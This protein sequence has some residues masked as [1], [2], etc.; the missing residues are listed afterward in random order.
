MR[1]LKKYQQIDLVKVATQVG[2]DVSIWICYG[3]GLFWLSE[4]Q[5]FGLLYLYSAFF[6]FIHIRTFLLQH[7]CGHGSLFKSKRWSNFWGR[8]FSV[9]STFPYYLWKAD[10][11]KH[12]AN[13]GEKT[14][15]NPGEL[16]TPSTS[17]KMTIYLKIA[18][19]P[20][21]L[22]FSWVYFFNL[23]DVLHT[24]KMRKVD[25]DTKK[26]IIS[27]VT[28]LC[29]MVFLFMSLYSLTPHAL[30][31]YLLGLYL[32][33]IVAVH[34]FYVQHSHKGMFFKS[35]ERYSK[36]SVALEGSSYVVLPK[37]L[38]IFVFRNITLH[39][40]H[41]LNFRIPNYRL[42]E[43]H[44][45]HFEKNGQTDPRITKITSIKDHLN[46]YKLK[47]YDHASGQWTLG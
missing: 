20:A 15:D 28:H 18:R 33:Y 35:S 7:D 27:Q 9:V 8:I 3:A 38:R 37:F 45:N 29:A 46:C 2:V 30:Y 13:L 42:Y 41:H 47:Q 21:I 17:D 5:H 10:H 44:C 6:S 24:W 19:S 39:H 36:F 1:E 4:A 11:N 14:G 43:A 22:L 34:F 25:K 12:H 16:P 32:A 26:R 31:A 40:I 23:H